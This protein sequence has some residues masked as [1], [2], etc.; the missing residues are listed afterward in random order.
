MTGTEKRVVDDARNPLVN[1]AP[2]RAEVLVENRRQKRVRETDRPV[3]AL[4][5]VRGE[6]R[7]ERVSRNAGT[8]EE[9][10]RRGAQRRR[11]G[12]RLASERGQVG[13]PRAHELLERLG[14]REGLEGIDVLVESSRHLEREEGIAA[15][16]FVDTEQCLAREGPSQPVAQKSMKRPD[17]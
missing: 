6:R 9:R 12:E 11:D 1:A 8:L 10:L 7:L 17:A 16:P 13:D 4:D 15:R 3:L 5:D 2:R 14:Y